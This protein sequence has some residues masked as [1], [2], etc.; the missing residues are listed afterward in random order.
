MS[1]RQLLASV[2]HRPWPLPSGKW[3]LT[4]RWTDLLFAHWPVPAA[5]IARLLPKGFAV[6][7]FKGTAWVGIVPFRMERVKLRGLPRLP[8]NH[9]FAEANVRTYV[10][11][12]TSGQTGVY[13]LSLDA[14][15]PLAVL[16]ARSWYHLPYFLAKM[17]VQEQPDGWLT[18]SSQRLFSKGAANVRV[19]Y[20]CLPHQQ[21]FE[22]S[23]PGTIEH[24]LTER[25]AL[26]TH[27]GK[28]LIRADIHHQQWRLEP[29]EAQFEDLS[30]AA[31]QSI[32]LPASAPLL[33]FSRLLD[34]FA[35]PPKTIRQF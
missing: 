24:F 29:A 18:Y 14:S 17:K 25:Y 5:D 19:R 21:H 15:N 26:F 2:E 4:M 11:D 27:S 8:G 35:W 12:E 13:F 6:D 32:R 16:A 23:R 9:L 3:A 34:V 7:T 1:N 22:G 33:H 30:V 28:R 20:R 10:R 31:A